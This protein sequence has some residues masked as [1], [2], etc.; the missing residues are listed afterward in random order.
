MNNFYIDTT[1]FRIRIYQGYLPELLLNPL[2]NN[3]LSW[4]N[5]FRATV[6]FLYPW[7]HQHSRD[8]LMFLGDREKE[9][10]RE[11]SGMKGY[12]IFLCISERPNLKALIINIE[13]NLLFMKK[14]H[15]KSLSFNIREQGL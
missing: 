13:W 8:Y 15:E 3:R 6:L 9:R 10:K 11:S 12:R 14:V 2:S 5:L 1:H 4:V 7:K